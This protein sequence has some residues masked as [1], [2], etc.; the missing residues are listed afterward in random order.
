MTAP[1]SNS[2]QSDIVEYFA[3]KNVW[4]INSNKAKEYHKLIGEMIAVDNQPFSIVNDMGFKHLI[5]KAVPKYKMPSENY[6]KETVLPNIYEQCKGTLQKIIE[7]R[8]GK[9][10]FTTDIWTSNSNKAF[11]SLTGHWISNGT[12]CSYVL[13]T[14]GFPGTHSGETIAR[15]LTEM[16]NGWNLAINDV[17]AVIAD[18]AGN[19]KKAMQEV[20]I[21]YEPCF[22]HTLQLIIHDGINS[23]RAIN[24]VIAKS[25]K[26]V[27]HF[28]Y[29]QLA[30]NKLEQ[31]QNQLNLKKK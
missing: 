29:S 8:S 9:I 3:T 17:H 2:T 31:F 22:I 18:N 4:D 12:R 25:R 11:I 24:D 21:N 10:S 28:S 6:F 20:N 13:N 27:G 1:K 30:C 19:M 23:Q 16:L 7:A 5:A 15:C 26:I 14:K